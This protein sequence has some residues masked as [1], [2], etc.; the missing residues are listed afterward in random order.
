M[1]NVLGV[2]KTSGRP[3]F[4]DDAE[5]AKIGAEAPLYTTV[6]EDAEL[7]TTVKTFSLFLLYWGKVV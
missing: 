4:Q 1:E 3:R 2:A 7:S 6:E 5:Q